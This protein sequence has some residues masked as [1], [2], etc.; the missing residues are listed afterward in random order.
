M[1]LEPLINSAMPITP[2][3]AAGVL[4]TLVGAVQLW[5]TKGTVL[6][7][8]LG[9]VW[10]GLILFV[11]LTGFFIFESDV[12]TPFNY[13]SKPLSALVL[14]MLWRG[15]R[16]A[17]TGKIKEHR[18]T[19]IQL[20]CLTMLIGLLTIQPGR[21]VHQMLTSASDPSAAHQR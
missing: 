18:Q 5:L 7:R 10:A 21:V 6:H 16:L 9:F 13:L 11:A 2:H 15:V 3:T 1:T 20:F 14:V 8:R 4:A 12:A 19:M 17:R